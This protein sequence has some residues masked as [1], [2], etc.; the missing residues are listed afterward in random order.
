MIHSNL[1]FSGT[2]LDISTTHRRDQEI[3][4]F[5]DPAEADSLT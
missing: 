4:Q 5:A 2:L 3:D 1:L